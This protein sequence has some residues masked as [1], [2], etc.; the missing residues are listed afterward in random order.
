MLR[1][2]APAAVAAFG[3]ITAAGNDQQPQPIGPRRAVDEK[4]G[5]LNLADGANMKAVR[6][7]R[8]GD[9]QV[10]FYAFATGRRA[11]PQS[12]EFLGIAG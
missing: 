12:D 3:C 8:I 10:Q 6:L 1:N 11:R 9:F 5:R 4:A 2:F 7:H